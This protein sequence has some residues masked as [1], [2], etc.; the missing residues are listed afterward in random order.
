MYVYLYLYALKEVKL[1]RLTMPQKN[2][3]LLK[4]PVPDMRNLLWNGLTEQS[5]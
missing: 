4:P 5:K 2:H 3:R 1:L